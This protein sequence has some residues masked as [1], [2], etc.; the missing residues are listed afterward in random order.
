MSK[1]QSIALIL[2]PKHSEK[3]MH[4]SYFTLRFK[5]FRNEF[6]QNKNR[7]KAKTFDTV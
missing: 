3:R 1:N 7:E 2:E 4:F 6:G 5:H